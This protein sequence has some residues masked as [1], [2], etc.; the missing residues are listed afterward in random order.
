MVGHDGEGDEHG[1]ISGCLPEIH[2]NGC[3]NAASMLA[4]CI[5]NPVPDAP[6]GGRVP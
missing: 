3:A 2:F 5:P 4:A 1:Q 6:R